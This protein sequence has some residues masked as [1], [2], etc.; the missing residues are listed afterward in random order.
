MATET[1]LHIH[2]QEYAE[3]KSLSVAPQ[4]CQASGS[5]A[6]RT[7]RRQIEGKGRQGG[8]PFGEVVDPPAE[9]NEVHD[10]L[11]GWTGRSP[12]FTSC[13]HSVPAGTALAGKGCK[14]R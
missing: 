14:A 6:E 11:V 2:R 9:E 1:G 4:V 3:Q 12:N 5:A 10:G 8:E 13:A 7:T